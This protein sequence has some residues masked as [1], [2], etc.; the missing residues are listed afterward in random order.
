MRSTEGGANHK[1]I[2][3][4]VTGLS[5]SRHYHAVTTCNNMPDKHVHTVHTY[6]RHHFT[7]FKRGCDF[8]SVIWEAEEEEEV[9]S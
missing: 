7:V 8:L 5:I 4:S 6:L 2:D 9:R 3:S 1:P